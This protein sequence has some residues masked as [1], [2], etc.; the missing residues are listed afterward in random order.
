[1]PEWPKTVQEGLP[2]PVPTPRRK[3]DPFVGIAVSTGVAA[4]AV[5]LRLVIDPYV[6][7]VQFITFF[8]AVMIAA[9][10]C[11]TRAGLLTTVL[12]AL[13][14]WYFFLE[15]FYSFAITRPAEAIALASFLVVSTILALSIGGLT[16]ALARERRY[17]ERQRLLAD[18]LNHRVKN[19]LTIVQAIA[20][21]TLKPEAC[22]PEVRAELESRLFALGSAHEVLTRRNWQPV[23][24][25]ELLTNLL[26]SIGVDAERVTLS[27]PGL[28]LQPKTAITMT[29][30]VHELATNAL[31]Y[32]ALSVGGGRVEIDWR[33]DAEKLQVRWQEHDG[34]AVQAP[35]KRGFGTSMVEKA[36]AR[37]FGG[38]AKIQFLRDGV[39]CLMEAPMNDSEVLVIT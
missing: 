7:G 33:V 11:G 17:R 24:L 38:S 34:P 5:V 2:S 19:N 21:Q 15:P 14:G 27:G 28:V 12:C 3:P 31:K 6:T 18:E 35:V 26:G 22:R 25:T 20:R 1:M 16:A 39:I 9:Y 36:L 23:Q 8:P 13:A 10:L 37:D 4:L 29:L 32:G 30:A